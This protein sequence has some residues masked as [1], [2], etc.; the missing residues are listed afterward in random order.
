MIKVLP[1]KKIYTRLAPSKIHGVGVIAIKSIKKGTNIFYGDEDSKMVWFEKKELKN[2]PKEI[3]K[4]YEDFCVVVEKK[5]RILYGCP[6]NFNMMTVSWYL[7]HSDNPNVY[8]DEDYVFHALKNI[9]KGEELTVN[10]DS[11]SLS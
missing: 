3:K 1:H 6:V 9:K 10:Y 2:L 8:C 11:Y 4:L 5:K 7:N